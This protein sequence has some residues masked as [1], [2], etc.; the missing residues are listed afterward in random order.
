[1]ENRIW[2]KDEGLSWSTITDLLGNDETTPSKLKDL[3][4]DLTDELFTQLKQYQ[5]A[6]KMLEDIESEIDFLK[7]N[8]GSCI[9]FGVKRL[10]YYNRIAYM[11]DREQKVVTVDI[12]DGKINVEELN[13]TFPKKQESDNAPTKKCACC[14]HEL[15]LE[16]FENGSDNCYIC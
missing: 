12:E 11:H 7:G 1:M 9:N 8:I 15:P 3:T 10:N 2:T 14:G 5:A 6:R 16:Y 4:L 13:L